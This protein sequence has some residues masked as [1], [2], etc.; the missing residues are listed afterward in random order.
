[1]KADIMI[2]HGNAL[3]YPAVKEGCELSLSRKG[4]PGKLKFSVVKDELLSFSE[5]DAV[6]LTID[7]ECVFYGFVFTKSRSSSAPYL[8]DVTCYDQTRYLKNS[9]TYN[10]EGKTTGELVRM[11]AEDFCLSVGELSD[12]GFPISRS[13]SDTSLFDVIQNSIDDTLMSTGKLFVLYDDEGALTLKNAEDMKLDLLLD[14]DT[15]GGYSYESTIDSRTY[16]QIK[17]VL[18]DSESGVK[19]VYIAKDTENINKWGVLQYNDTVKT[20]ANGEA[21]ANALLSLY[22]SVTRNL[23]VSDA[24]GDIRVKGGSSVIVNL[25][26]GDVSVLNYMLVESVTH[27]FSEN[28]HL[29]DLKLRG[30]E[31]V[32]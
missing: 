17:V 2:A 7:G 21:K 8:I 26:L 3:Y 15:M 25:E 31:F 13:D 32:T 9:D 10:Y 27:K 24:L 23:S 22:N 16:N 12:T 29:M 14:V 18:D 6:K 1:L 28:Q 4:T 20:Q 19:K 30:G 11:I 5:G